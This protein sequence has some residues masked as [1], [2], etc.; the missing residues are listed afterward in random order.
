MLASYVLSRTLV[1]TLAKYLL[2]AARAAR[3]H[4]ARVARIR[5]CGCSGRS[6]RGFE[7]FAS[8]LPRAARAAASTRRRV[9][10]RRLPRGVRRVA[11]AAPWV[12]EDFFPA[13]DSG[14]FKLHLRA[15]TGTRIEETARL[16][17]RV[18]EAIRADDP[19]R[20]ARQHHRQHRP[21]VQ[22]HQPLVQQLGADRPAG[23]RHPG[24]ARRRA[25][26]DRR[27][28]P[29]PAARRCPTSFPGVTFSFLPADIV[30]QILNFGLP[31]PIDVQIVGR[32]PR[33]QPRGRRDAAGD[34]IWRG[35]PASSTCASSRPFD[36]PQLHVDVDRTRAAQVGF[37]QRDVASNLLI[38]LSAAA[39]RRRRRSGSTRERRQLHRSR[40]R[41]RSTAIDSLAGPRNIPLARHG[42]A[43]RSADPRR[44]SRSVERGDA[45]TA[46]VSHYNV[47]PVIDI[48]G[49]VQGRDLGGVARGDRSDRRRRP[50]R[51]CRA[52]RRSSCAARSRPCGRRS[53]GCSPAWCSRSCSSTC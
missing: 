20:R 17:D 26:A 11:A 40:R 50:R 10:A 27:I 43:T 21:A 6:T 41:R 12:G 53:P 44:R 33:G 7:R 37:T 25:P 8:G 14:Q 29:R 48:Y 39:A 32:E 47:Q 35:C 19:A 15:P 1:P 38:S 36:Q 42:R 23:R 46:V 2:Q 3:R 28:R 16:C 5:S 49:A 24:D 45:S 51:T 4:G 52:D 22:R 30:S 13:V 18:E 9:F 31:A 34:Q